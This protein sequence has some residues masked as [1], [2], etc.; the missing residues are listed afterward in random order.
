[1]LCPL[2]RTRKARRACPAL[3]QTICAVCCG[4]KRLTEI[5]CPAD[6]VYLASAREHPAAVV[7]RQQ[8][9]D[10]ALLLPTIQHLSERQYQLFFLLQTVIARHKPEGFV[11]LVDDDVAEAAAALAATLETASRGVIYE[12][13]TQSAVAQR[14]VVEMKGLLGELREQRV[15]VYDGEAA[16]VLRAIEQGARDAR[17]AAAGGDVAYLALVGRLLQQNAQERR[18]DGHS[19]EPSAT[20]NP[21]GRPSLILPDTV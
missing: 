3:G 15:K 21:A 5:A 11:R 19:S 18:Q 20:V 10:V 4:T 7:R 13:A 17:K 12:H 8:E 6:C 9:R 1:M 16:I 2:C 14:L